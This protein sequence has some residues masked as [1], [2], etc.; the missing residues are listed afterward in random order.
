MKGESMDN[1]KENES[2]K[3]VKKSGGAKKTP[4][5][6]NKSGESK[7]SPVKAGVPNNQPNANLT[8]EIKVYDRTTVNN[9]TSDEEIKK[10][11][12]KRIK[13]KR[14]SKDE[15]HKEILDNMKLTYEIMRKEEIRKV[16]AYNLII[17]G[18][19]REDAELFLKYSR[20]CTQYKSPAYITRF[21]KDSAIIK[22]ILSIGYN[23]KKLV[24]I[25]EAAY[26][27]VVAL[28]NEQKQKEE[29][30][31]NLSV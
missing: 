28:E 26:R 12:Y 20:R 2:T 23:D 1:Q 25:F 18:D 10:E 9:S 22:E 19:N 6:P 30:T 24:D 11:I 3:V 7:K 15:M 17:N 13:F 27:A 21:E 5:K 8:G 16:R 4:G 14:K 31:D 29:A